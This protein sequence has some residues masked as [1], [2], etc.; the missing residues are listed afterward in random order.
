MLRVTTDAT[1]KAPGEV[2]DKVD[3]L[4]LRYLPSEKHRESQM[5]W[6]ISDNSLVKIKRRDSEDRKTSVVLIRD[7]VFNSNTLANLRWHMRSA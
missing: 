5:N 2:R 6:S 4:I 3:A 1:R 7:L